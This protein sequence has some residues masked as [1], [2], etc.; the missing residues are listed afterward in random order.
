MEVSRILP[1]QR[2][3]TRLLRLSLCIFWAWGQG[4]WDGCTKAEQGQ[5]G[6]LG[7][8]GAPPSPTPLS[9]GHL[10]WHLLALLGAG[11][12]PPPS[13]SPNPKRKTFWEPMPREGR[14]V[15]GKISGDLKYFQV[16]ALGGTHAFL[17]QTGPLM[18]FEWGY[19][20]QRAFWPAESP[21]TMQ[22][23][24]SSQ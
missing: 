7:K 4:S 13:S 22:G 15:G 5:T 16:L 11:P 23:M 20:G 9:L 3:G 12:D 18:S 17:L 6:C 10:M 24:D 14:L 8:F 21:G 1:P 2:L 19:L